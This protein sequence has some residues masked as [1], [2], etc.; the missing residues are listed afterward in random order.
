MTDE[1]I[2][3]LAETMCAAF[4]SDDPILANTITSPVWEG[5]S[6]RQRG[7]WRRAARAVARTLNGN[8]HWLDGE[9]TNPAENGLGDGLAHEVKRLLTNPNVNPSPRGG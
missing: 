5:L 9:A 2:N 7:N 1:Q 8:R 4:H 6:G 3:L